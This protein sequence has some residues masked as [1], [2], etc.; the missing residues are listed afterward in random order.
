MAQL[1]T[2]QEIRQEEIPE[3]PNWFPKFLTPL[4]LFIRGVYG[5]L[6]KQLTFQDNISSQIRELSFTTTSSYDDG[7]FPSVI[8]TRTT[9]NKAYSLLV[10]QLLEDADNFTPIANGVFVDW[11]EV[12]GT[13]TIAYVSGL[14]PSTRYF[15]R[16][17][18]F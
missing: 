6:N 11:R 13:I 4:N 14:Q 16:V 5:A 1:P 8:F 18:I 2:Q 7:D 15:M 10:C 12:N 17:M 3:A 9:P